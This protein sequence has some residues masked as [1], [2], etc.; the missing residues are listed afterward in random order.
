MAN[1]NLIHEA[2]SGREQA[3]IKHKILEKY[4]EKLTAILAIGKKDFKFTYVDCFAGPWQA[5]TA[6]MHTTSIA[7][8]LRVLEQCKRIIE[9]RG[10][11]VVFRALFIEQDDVAY[12]HLEKYLNENTP[13]G[14]VA[15]SIHGEF[16]NSRQSILDWVGDSGHAFF[17]IDPKGWTEVKVNT[18][19]PILARPRSEFVINFMYDFI[20]R[21]ASM[22]RHTLDMEDLIGE[23]V[24]E[25]MT[26][27]NRESKLSGA[28]RKNL[29]KKVPTRNIDYPVRSAYVKILDPQKN[30]TKYHLIYVTT[31]PK[32]IIKFMETIEVADDLQ[33][34]VRARIRDDKKVQKT[35]T[36]DLFA[37]DEP[38]VD[39]SLSKANEP[40]IDDYW[41]Q[42]I[43]TER[44]IDEAG[45]ADILEETNWFPSELQASL[46][47]LILNKK[48]KN[49]D[50]PKPRPKRP[51]HFEKNGGETL[52]LAH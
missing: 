24:A 34:K 18:L 43:G 37:E 21:T 9:N 28:Y 44:K 42:H 3:A 8:S 47:R 46:S 41:L 15:H 12:P 51:L 35:R 33:E 22:E 26:D 6:E 14:I 16:V 45:F 48:I 30:R 1:N 10:G 38:Y 7:I 40:K 11:S 23:P 49:L 20:N 4:L 2:Y 39:E 17:F 31:H 29:K 5:N 52:R 36:Q 27:G 50:A 13:Q 32:G 25:L 19:A